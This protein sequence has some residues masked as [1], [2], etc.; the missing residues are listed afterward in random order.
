L[1]SDG[2]SLDPSWTADGR[3]LFARWAPDDQVNNPL[4]SM[5]AD[6]SNARQ[7]SFPQQ[8]LGASPNQAAI[9]AL[10]TP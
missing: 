5:D 1:T 4:W 9:T 6:G 2:G 8:L 10:T 3:I 7:L